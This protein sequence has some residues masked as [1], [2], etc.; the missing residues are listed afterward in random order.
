MTAAPVCAAISLYTLLG[1][2][3]DGPA[4]LATSMIGLEIAPHF[5]KPF[6]AE[7]FTSLWGRRWNMSVGNTLR[8]LIYDPIQEGEASTASAVALVQL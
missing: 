8:V 7:S 2:I 6:F 4:S 5:N 3:Y 1:C